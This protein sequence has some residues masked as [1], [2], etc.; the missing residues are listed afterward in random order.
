MQ[1]VQA[2]IQCDVFLCYDSGQH[3]SRIFG[4]VRW[5]EANV[6]LTHGLLIHTFPGDLEMCRS[7]RLLYWYVSE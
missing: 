1:I 3:I 5:R 6:W 2:E 7:L 4:S